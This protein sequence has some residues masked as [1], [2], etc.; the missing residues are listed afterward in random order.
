MAAATKKITGEGYLTSATL[1]TGGIRFVF[2]NCSS[3]CS[4]EQLKRLTKPKQKDKEVVKFAF[5]A[6]QPDLPGTEQ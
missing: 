3:S 2:D 1:K 5:E 4:M 6:E